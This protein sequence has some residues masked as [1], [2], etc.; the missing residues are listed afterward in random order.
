MHILNLIIELGKVYWLDILIVVML[1]VVLFFLWKKGKKKQVLSIINWLVS[2]AEKEL[3]SKTGKYK[4]GKVIESLYNRL[5]V[6]ITLFFTKKEIEL[7]IDQA[8]KDLKEFLKRKEN[9]LESL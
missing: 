6:V 4:K 3:G 1:L 5:P 9:N 8:A 2:E 7:F